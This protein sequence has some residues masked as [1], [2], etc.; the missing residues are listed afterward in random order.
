MPILV[1]GQS[2]MIY[3]HNGKTIQGKVSKIAEHTVL[4]TYEGE[5]A[6][7]VLGKYAI[8]KVV[9]GKSGREQDISEKIKI[10]SAD[11]WE[12]VIIIEDLD[13]VTGMSRVGEVKGKTAAYF[14]YRSA[15]GN[16]RKSEENLKK[17]AAE[18]GCPFIL[19]TA[20]K[21]A[22]VGYNQSGNVGQQQIKKGVAYKY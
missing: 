7:Q 6:E 20:D 5:D 9:Y 16:D 13:A 2:D 18:M 3:L 4:F 17:M 12:K 22:G 11:D 1:S 15:A 10:N 8:A 21:S 14:N 19:L